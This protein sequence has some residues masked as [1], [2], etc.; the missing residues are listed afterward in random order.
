MP[1]DIN[2]FFLLSR[3][4]MSRGH[5]QITGTDHSVAEHSYY[6]SLLTLLYGNSLLKDV[7]L[8]EDVDLEREELLTLCV[9]HDLPEIYTGDIPTTAKAGYRKVFKEIE[10]RA[11][12]QLIGELSSP[13]ID[14]TDLSKMDFGAYSKN[15]ISALKVL[16][17]MEFLL[18]R[19]LDYRKGNSF[20]MMYGVAE[21]LRWLQNTLTQE[22]ME[23]LQSW[24]P[25]SEVS[26]IIE[27]LSTGKAFLIN[28]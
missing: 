24:Q 7:F 14:T 17:Q 8:S 11:L 26:K 15:S 9:I 16:D 25:Y 22:E 10:S 20:A 27:G 21:N 12:N 28:E 4:S 3:M 13:Y 1:S 2:R 6:M 23:R 5:S 19:I 18:S